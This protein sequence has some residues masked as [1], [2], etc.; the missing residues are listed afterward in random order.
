MEGEGYGNEE[1]VL[2]SEMNAANFGIKIWAECE[3][4]VEHSTRVVELTSTAA[5]L[6]I[7]N[8]CHRTALE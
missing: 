4:N 5:S 8:V 3:M 1:A 6:R 7:A 2:T